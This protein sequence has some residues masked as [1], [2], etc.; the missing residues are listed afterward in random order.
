MR[1]QR[2]NHD[3]VVATLDRERMYFE[4]MFRDQERDPGVLYWLAVDAEG[5]APVESSPAN[6]DKKHLEF[7][8]RVLRKG[9]RTRLATEMYLVPPFIERAIADTQATEP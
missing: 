1:F 8:T 6:V 5:G 7:M 9:S 4:A 3:A 2:D